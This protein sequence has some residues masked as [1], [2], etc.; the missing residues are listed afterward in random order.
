MYKTVT[1]SLL[2]PILFFSPE[3]VEAKQIRICYFSQQ[4]KC[5]ENNFPN[6]NSNDWTKKLPHFIYQLNVLYQCLANILIDTWYRLGPVA[7]EQPNPFSCGPKGV[8]ASLTLNSCQM[9]SCK[10]SLVKIATVL[11]RR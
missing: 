5:G 9:Y 10:V 2:S 3:M 4:I 8:I 6:V 7:A 11:K 1:V